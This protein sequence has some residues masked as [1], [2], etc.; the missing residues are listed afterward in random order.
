MGG[1]LAILLLFWCGPAPAAEQK[2]VVLNDINIT[3][4]LGSQIPLNEEFIDESGKAVKLGSYFDGKQPVAIILNYYGCPLLCGVLLNV[5]KASFE[6]INW[7]PGHQYKIV[8]ISFDPKEKFDLAAAKKKSI[9]DSVQRPEFKAAMANGWH[10]LVGKSGSEARLAA[11]LGFHYKWIEEDGQ[12]AHGTALFLASP[13]GKLSRVMLGL[14]FPPKDLKLALLQAGEGK[15]G[16]FAE[17]LVLFCYHWEPK[18][19]KFVLLA[20]RLVTIGGA[21]TVVALVVAYLL[22]FLRERRKGNACSL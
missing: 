14:E 17:K 11:A 13:T 6:A 7:L 8:T 3:P 1:W 10:F 15:V 5:A 16:T 19:N 4:T 2:P 22:W 9:S 18:D 12:W 21:V 20:S